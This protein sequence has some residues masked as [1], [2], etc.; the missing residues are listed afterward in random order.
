LAQSRLINKLFKRKDK[1]VSDNVYDI[2]KQ[3]LETH[4][5]LCAERYKRLEDKFVT[6]DVRLE[7]LSE[8]VHE[9][10]RKQSEDMEELKEIIQ[11][12]SEHRFKAIVAASATIVAALISALAYVVTKIPV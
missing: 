2:E 8:E 12:S 9:M 3:N 4:V 6:L 1:I 7:K 5:T 11:R 10:K